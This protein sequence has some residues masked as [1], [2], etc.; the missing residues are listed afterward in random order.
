MLSAAG[1]EVAEA[2]GLF[3]PAH[4][5]PA[6]DG[7][8][9]LQRAEKAFT[10]FVAAQQHAGERMD[11]AS[12]LADAAARYSHTEPI[13]G[14]GLASTA[15]DYRPP[16]ACSTAASSTGRACSTGNSH[17]DGPGTPSA[18]CRYHAQA[19]LPR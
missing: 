12:H 19:A 15:N 11:G 8:H 9:L 16:Y 5:R 1:R 14:G 6:A 13:S 3:P 2:R 10:S 17:A 18:P 4:L 7:G